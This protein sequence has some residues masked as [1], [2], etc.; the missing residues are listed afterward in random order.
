MRN[1]LYSGMI[2]NKG[3]KTIQIKTIFFKKTTKKKLSS[4]YRISVQ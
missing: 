3:L 1:I 4:C 2:F